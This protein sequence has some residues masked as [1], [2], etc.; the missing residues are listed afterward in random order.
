MRHPIAIC[1]PVYNGARF[2]REAVASALAQTHEP[3][4]IIV[5]DN[6]S[7]DGT[8]AIL[9]EFSDRRL[10]VLSPREHLG[11]AAN[12]NRCIR[13]AGPGYV[14]ML[15]ADDVLLPDALRILVNKV[16]E[17]PE[18]EVFVGRASY[19]I[20]D[21]GRSLDRGIYRH[22]PGPVADFEHFT[23]A[24]PFPVNINSVLLRSEIARFREDCGVVTD[25]D[26]MI[27]FGI[28]KRKVILLGDE[29]IRYR[30]HD[31]AT[32]ANRIPMFIQSLAVYREYL[33]KSCRPHLYQMRIFRMLFWCSV[34]LIDG[35]G[36]DDARKVVAEYRDLVSPVQCLILWLALKVPWKISLM[37][38]VRTLRGRL[39]GAHS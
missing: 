2:I 25:L 9:A 20:E 31:G 29:L 27:R 21:G 18:G 16:A 34:L 17:F 11:M 33:G 5:C 12:W 22:E 10:R 39:I 32:S 8:A 24:N 7:T 14:L 4:D 23:V 26:M 37:E 28:E 36:R 19:L 15:S 38:K 35:G 3:L 1:I 6:V 13:A 30:I